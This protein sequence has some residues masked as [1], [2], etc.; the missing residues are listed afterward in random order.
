MG[1]A[2]F[3]LG[4]AGSRRVDR[5]TGVVEQAAFV[6]QDDGTQ[7]FVMVHEPPAEPR[8]G[9]LMFSSILADF[10]SNYQREV[11]LA[12]SLAAAGLVVMRFHYRGTGNSDG[13]AADVTLGS[14]QDDG[15]W[16]VDFMGSRLGNLP[17][18]L[19]GTRWGSLAAAA[20]ARDLPTGPVVLCEP[21]VDASRYFVEAWRSRAMSAVA[22]GRTAGTGERLADVIVR[23]GYADVVGNVIHRALFDSAAGGGT[24]DEY[25][26]A[27][28]P[29]LVVQFGGNELRP[30]NRTLRDHLDGNGAAVET[31]TVDLQ[32]SWWF[33]SG[34]RIVLHPELNRLI[35]GWFVSQ[36]TTTEVGR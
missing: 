9:V 29:V 31:S 5:V 34:P 7:L 14:L 1:S 26:L 32:E 12:R 16:S 23:Q 10:M 28:R 13:D 11:H 35:A 15:R 8:G 18:G 30:A 27:R 2:N 24:L 21:V 19:L 6:P 25:D 22:L 3:D 36:V 17:L 33:R 4:V 20:A